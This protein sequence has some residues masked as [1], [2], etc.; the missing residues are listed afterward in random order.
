LDLLEKLER[1]DDNFPIQ[2]KLFL[3]NIIRSIQNS[4]KLIQ[5]SRGMQPDLISLNYNPILIG[6]QSIIDKIK[7]W[8]KEWNDL[9]EKTQV[10][11]EIFKK[12]N[13]YIKNRKKDEKKSNLLFKGEQFPLFAIDVNNLMISYSHMFPHKILPKDDTPIM[14]IKKRYLKKEPFLANF[15][16]SRHLFKHLHPIPNDDYHEYYIESWYKDKNINEHVDVDTSLSA[17]SGKHIER[18][19]NQIS[20]FYIGSGDKD[21]R[22]L[23]EQAREYKIPVSLIVVSKDNVSSDMEKFIGD[24]NIETLY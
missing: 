16:A 6:T 18:Y 23:V 12:L 14:R 3:Q 4:I 22:P 20:H 8:N 5:N 19:K 7:N 1:A 21:F 15:F 10:F 17:Y 9:N 11:N 2:S 13:Q 24:S